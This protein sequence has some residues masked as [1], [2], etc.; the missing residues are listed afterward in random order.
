MLIS[1]S[2]NQ[3]EPDFCQGIIKNVDLELTVEALADEFKNQNAFKVGRLGKTRTVLLYFKG[4]SLPS[5]VKIGF[6][7]FKVSEYIPGPVR[8]YICQ[9]FGHI[10]SSCK[11][12][13]RCVRCSAN[14]KVDDCPVKEN[15][16]CFR[17]HGS[18]SAAWSECPFV[19]EAK[20]VSNIQRVEK[21]SYSAAL[22]KHCQ[23]T[24]SSTPAS[25]LVSAITPEARA[26]II[27]VVEESTCPKEEFVT[28]P[29]DSFVTFIAATINAAHDLASK[30][31]RIKAVCEMAK[32]FY[33]LRLNLTIFTNLSNNLE[34]HQ[35][36]D[37]FVLIFSPFALLIPFSYEEKHLAQLNNAQHDASVDQWHSRLKTRISLC[38]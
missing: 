36:H 22:K 11:G 24:V 28:L 5:S 21:V 3:S 37:T 33:G 8:C 15:P 12:T 13:P 1:V 35:H 19:H 27:Q 32:N 38:A 14:H 18:H 25:Q 16:T 4:K 2:E 6:M 9:Q 10:S 20:F 29:A 23:S 7:S 17:C 30:S 34:M 31:D 26:H